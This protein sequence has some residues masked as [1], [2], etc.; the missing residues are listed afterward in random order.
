[1]LVDVEAFKDTSAG[2]VKAFARCSNYWEGCCP[3]QTSGE[4]EANTAGG[5]GYEEPW[6]GH[7]ASM[8]GQGS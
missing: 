6:L 2:L 4:L 1:M 7:G 3:E 5:G 8:L